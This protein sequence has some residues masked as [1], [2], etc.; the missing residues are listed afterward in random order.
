MTYPVWPSELPAPERDTWQASWSDPRRRRQGD[1]GPDGYRKR[2]SSIPRQV[3]L[4][5][6]LNREEK[7]RFDRFFEDELDFG[8]GLFTMPDP[9]TDGWPVLTADGQPLLMEDG[10]PITMAQTW[11]CQWGA[12]MPVETIQGR[13]FRIRFAVEVL[14]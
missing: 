12:E 7:A 8:I 2:F 6:V 11:L 1:A 10:T 14:P 9:T 3:A 13:E 4:S 5:M